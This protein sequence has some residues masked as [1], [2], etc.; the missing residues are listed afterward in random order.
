M[1]GIPEIVLGRLVISG[2]ICQVFTAATGYEMAAR[3][4]QEN[5]YVGTYRKLLEV[6][7]KTGHGGMFLEF[8]PR[9]FLHAGFSK[10]LAMIPYQPLSWQPADQASTMTSICPTLLPAALPTATASPL[11]GKP[12]FWIPFNT[13]LFPSQQRLGHPGLLLPQHTQL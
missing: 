11:T 5:A 2:L 4:A 8:A 1:G 6:S 9:S 12:T 7:Q 13:M 3:M 10:D